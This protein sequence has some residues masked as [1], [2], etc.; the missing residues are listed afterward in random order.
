MFMEDV[1]RRIGDRVIESLRTHWRQRSHV[2]LGI[3]LEGGRVDRVDVDPSGRVRLIGWTVA[4][5]PPEFT[6]AVNGT[7]ARAVRWF[8]LSRSDHSMPRR[9]Y[10]IEFAGPCNGLAR[11]VT[12]HLDGR[13]LTRLEPLLPLQEPHYA[14]LL[15]EERVL[16]RADIYGVGPPS[17]VASAEIVAMARRLPGPI[18]DFGCGSGALVRELRAA[19]METFGLELSRREIVSSLRD[20]VSRYVTLYDGALPSPF[21]EGRFQAV[22]CTEVLEHIPEYKLAAKELARLAPRALVTVPDMSAIPTLFPHSVVPWHLLEATHVN[23]F[24]Q[25]SLERL[26]RQFFA[27]VSFSRIGAFQVNGTEVFSSLVAHCER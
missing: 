17:P 13:E 27:K 25:P 3:A 19:G 24:T 12:V 22:V 15:D 10:C 6:V 11:T 8:E 26:L 2:A 7:P 5:V 4:P 18:L 14:S 20:D 21:P 23:F 16:H 1:V 9:G